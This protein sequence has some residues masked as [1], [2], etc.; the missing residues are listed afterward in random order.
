M[1]PHGD[2]PLRTAIPKA[3]SRLTH[4]RCS[5]SSS[6]TRHLP[7]DD[8]SNRFSAER[9]D[10]PVFGDGLPSLRRRAGRRTRVYTACVRYNPR[11]ALQTALPL[12]LLGCASTRVD[13]GVDPRL[14]VYPVGKG[15]R[16]VATGDLDRDGDID[17]AVVNAGSAD[18]SILLNDGHGTL[19]PA[20]GS[21]VPAGP[22]PA[23]IALADLDADGVLDLIIAN[24]ETSFIT[25]LRG[26]GHARYE[27]LSGSPFETGAHPHIHSVAAADFDGDNQIDL[28]VES[29]D[30]DTVRVLFGKGGA[31]DP[32]KSFATGRLPYYRLGTADISGEGNPDLLVPNQRDRSISILGGTTL[33]ALTPLFDPTPVPRQPWMVRSAD[34]DSDSRPDLAVIIDGGIA[35]LRNTGTGFEPFPASPIAIAEATDVAMGDIDGDGAADVAIGPWTG[36]D[37]CILSGKHFI[38]TTLRVGRRPIGLAIADLT[39]DGK[40]ELIAASALDDSIAVGR[41]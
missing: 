6:P 11:V 23:D 36:R 9:S 40:A 22:E 21:P 30:D 5:H 17:V 38:Q 3:A 28:A 26:D 32:P 8:G 7:A 37:I 13:S 19:A 31:F 35:L 1:A 10:D 16:V 20:P 29:A 15:P 14:M 18:V 34:L 25:I 12:L 4:A 2:S 39:G 24:H 41:P 33:G 27:P